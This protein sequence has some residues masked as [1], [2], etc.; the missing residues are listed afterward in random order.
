MPALVDDGLSSQRRYEDVWLDRPSY[1]A[2]NQP[3]NQLGFAGSFFR[4]KLLNAS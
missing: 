1:P 3:I 2:G 4:S